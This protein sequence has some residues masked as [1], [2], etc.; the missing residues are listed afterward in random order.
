MRLTIRRNWIAYA[1]IARK[2]IRRFMRIWTQTLVPPVITTT[3][4]FLI[5]GQLIGRRIGQMDG[6]Q[7]T[8]YIMPGLILMTVITNAYAN[9]SSSFY[10]TK[11]QRHIEEMLV[12]PIPG[13][14]I[15]AGY[16]TGG[17]VRGFLTA[18]I[19]TAVAF[20][21]TSVPMEHPLLTM[22]VVFMTALV[23]S[24]AGF[25]NAVFAR[26]FD[27]VSIVPTFILTPLT[28][29]GG[30]F[31]SVSLLGE[32]WQALSFANPILYMVNAFRFSVLGVAD[33]AIEVSMTV[34]LVFITGFLWLSAWLLRRGT[35]IKQ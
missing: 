26:T 11:F 30:V 1:T 31:Y 23:F 29:L 33:I 12:A 10:S 22:L 20:F 19:V 5:F 25:V 27:D 7:Y 16:L 21:F 13:W 24:S 3:L 4:Y 34:L 9:V 6:F 17:V 15:L 18:C 2:E 28:Y 35:G 32:P 14:I 8:D